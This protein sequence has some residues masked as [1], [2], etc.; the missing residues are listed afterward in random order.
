MQPLY[1]LVLVSS[2]DKPLS[3]GIGLPSLHSQPILTL[4]PDHPKREKEP[5]VHVNRV[6]LETLPG[7][8][9]ALL[10]V[11]Y[12]VPFTFPYVPPAPAIVPAP[13]LAPARPF[14]RPT[15]LV[16][17][18]PFPIL[19]HQAIPALPASLL[20]TPSILSSTI[21]MNSYRLRPTSLI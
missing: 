1:L 3:P 18:S 10:L 5:R 14:L 11:A 8:L 19:L 4:R 2:A 15:I 17:Q 6:Q 16:S 13:L 21:S 9:V 12:R 7:R 20:T